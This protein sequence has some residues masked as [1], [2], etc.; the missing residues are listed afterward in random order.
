MVTALRMSRRV[1]KGDSDG[2]MRLA[3]KHGLLPHV[4]IDASDPDFA[5]VQG[6]GID[7]YARVCAAERTSQLKHQFD[8][9]ALERIMQEHGHQPADWTPIANTWNE[10]AMRKKKVQ[11]RYVETCRKAR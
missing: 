1:M 2:A 9:A 11:A 6:V 8:Q 3:A 10:R 4:D 7:E 5:P